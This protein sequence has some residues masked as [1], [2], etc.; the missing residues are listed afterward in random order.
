VASSRGRLAGALVAVLLVT[1]CASIPTSGDVVEGDSVPEQLPVSVGFEA[2]EPEAGASETEIVQGFLD[3]MASYEAGYTT[4]KEF[5]TPDAQSV[6]NPAD[7]MTIY[8]SNPTVT[9]TGVGSVRLR[10]TVAA[11]ITPQAGYERRAPATATEIELTL[12]R[13]DGE[14]R[15][16]NPP[17]GLLVFEGDF[18]AEFREYNV[19]YFDA[20]GENL[21]PE[22]VYV[23]T[24]GN[25]AFLLAEALVRGPSRWLTPAVQSAFPKGTTVELPVTV[26]GGRAQVDL[27]ADAAI[28]TSE[29]QRELMT[30]QLA[31]TLDQVDGVQQV[32]VRADG[33]PLTDAVATAG[34][35][36]AF[37]EFN[38]DRLA[39]GELYAIADTGVVVGD[40]LV[41]VGGA[42]GSLAGLRSVA[43]DPRGGR[44]AVVDSTGTHLLWAPLDGSAEPAP[45]ASGANLHAVSWDRV[46]LVWFVDDAAGGSNIM[47]VKPDSEA[48]PV[49]MPD[50]LAEREIEDL[51]VSPDGSR[52]A[53][54]VEGD[55][56]VGIAQRNAETADASI[57]GLRRVQLDERAVTRVAWLGLTE[58]A[59]LVDEPGQTAE[60]YRV[61]LGGSNLSP[62]GPVQ[63]AVDL[64]AAPSQ[65]LAVSTAEGTVKRQSATLRW[66]DVG[67][68]H[69]PAYPG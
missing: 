8:S 45:L 1:G 38:P 46:G 24:Q 19:Y 62:A 22:P 3:A 27:S 9:R 5:L 20:E 47:V 31:W 15:I 33:L 42:L 26:E 55:V 49:Q 21:V 36:D 25:V 18:D 43:V 58:M 6:W 23:P 52:V 44:A 61:G 7:A 69:A 35:E 60:P 54:A 28:D 29:Q 68:A 63:D 37:S 34:P 2:D 14:W 66:V 40:R 57:E 56:L 67:S 17:K 30:A 41:P 4:A 64:A 32:V 10:L 51:A 50:A 13:I 53:I 59:V 48:M 11:V 16:A 65:E 39:G 12:Q